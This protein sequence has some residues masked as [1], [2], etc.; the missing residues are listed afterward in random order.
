NRYAL[1]LN[2]FC[3]PIRVFLL[4]VKGTLRQSLRYVELDANEDVTLEDVD[5]EVAMD[6]N[7]QGRMAESQAKVYNLDLQHAEKVLSMHDTDE[8]EPDDIEEM[9]EVVTTT[10]LMTEMVTTAAPITT[11]AQVPKPSA[12]KK[13]RGVVIQDHEEIAATSVIIHSEDEAFAR[14]LEAKINANINRNDVLEQKEDEEVA[15]QEKR[16]GDNLEQETAKKQRIYK[17]AEEL[18]TYLQIVV[19]DDDDVFIEATPLASKVFV[20]DYQIH[21]ENNKPYYKIIKAYR[22]HKLFLSFITLLKNFDREDLEALWK[23]VKE[24][25]KAT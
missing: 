16:Q 12:P 17:D 13:R 21:H 11:A 4:S 8:A 3:K 22:T 1:S 14:Q 18:K 6:A 7:I 15:V 9:L 20:V 10:K 2:M 25:F 5:S 24:R 19:N 23:L